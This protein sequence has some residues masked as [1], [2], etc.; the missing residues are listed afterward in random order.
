MTAQ[1]MNR[2][3]RVEYAIDE[4][5]MYSHHSGIAYRTPL[6][7]LMFDCEPVGIDIGRALFAKH[8]TARLADFVPRALRRCRYGRRRVRRFGWG[9]AR[10]A[11]R[12]GRTPPLWARLLR[13]RVVRWIGH[14]ENSNPDGKCTVGKDYSKDR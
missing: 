4:S 11:T 12:D 2:D 3:S 1:A 5:K 13:L 7:R 8:V 9:D 6:R 14:E 10:L